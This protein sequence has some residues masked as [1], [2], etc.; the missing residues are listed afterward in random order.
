MLNYIL[1]CFGEQLYLDAH[2]N[3][4]IYCKRKL[5]VKQ[6]GLGPQAHVLPVQD[7]RKQ[8]GKSE[9]SRGRITEWHLHWVAEFAHIHKWA[10]GQGQA[11]DPSISPEQREPPD[12]APLGCQRRLV[13]PWAT[14]VAHR[15]NQQKRLSLVTCKQMSGQYTCVAM[16]CTSSQQTL[17]FLFHF[18]LFSRGR[19]LKSVCVWKFKCQPLKMGPWL[20]QVYVFQQLERLE[21]IH[22]VWVCMLCVYLHVVRVFASKHQDR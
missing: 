3:D 7:P 15:V 22:I 14:C 17:G 5:H 18:Y 19:A 9:G 16:P 2:L 4:V 10:E 6:A 12:P 8:N 11:N 13:R 1:T 21:H 20:I